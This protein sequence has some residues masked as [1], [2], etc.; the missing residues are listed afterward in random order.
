[1]LLG[2]PEIRDALARLDGRIP[3]ASMRAMN[4]AVDVEHRDVSATVRE[5]LSGIP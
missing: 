5:F 3:E 4:Y 1:V 2:R